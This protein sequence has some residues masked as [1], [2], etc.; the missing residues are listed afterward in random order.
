MT[1]DILPRSAWT[2]TTNGWSTTLERLRV[3]GFVLHY[4]GDGTLIRKGNTRAQNAA[5]IRAYRHWQAVAPNGRRWPDIG[6]CYAVDQNGEAWTLA[7]D[8]VAAH[9]ATPA[10]TTAN[11]D[12]IGV[13]LILGNTETPTP[14]MIAAVNALMG[15][16]QG[17]FPNAKQILGHKQVKGASTACPGTAITARIGNG[18]IKIGGGAPAPVKPIP[19]AAPKDKWPAVALPPRTVHTDDS[20]N[21]WV[22]LLA[23]VGFTDKSL[24]TAIQ[25]WLKRLGYYKG[26]IE[27]DHGKTPVFGPMTIDALQRFLKSKDLYKGELDA[28]KRP[29]AQARGPMMIA[30]EIAYLNQQRRYYS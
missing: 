1:I 28:F 14:E 3:K 25:R 30:A 26:I 22:K 10:Y 16:L 5:L 27:T 2:T 19:P 23:D 9:S 13:L 24:T 11:R 29:Y 21:A 6:Y 15:T 4:P 20:H 12:Y 18:T 7:G 8:K 17:R